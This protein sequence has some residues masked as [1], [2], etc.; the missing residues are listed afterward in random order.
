MKIAAIYDIHGNLPALEAVLNEIER[1][2]VDL[3]LVGGDVAAG[4]MPR[5]T[6]ER[7]MSL[8]N[9]AQYI[10]GNGDRYLI[11]CFDGVEMDPRTSSTSR[12][13]QGWVARQIEQ[14][15]RDFVASFA[16]QAILPVEG[17]GTVLFCH[18]SPRSD[19]EGITTTTSEMELQ[20]MLAGIRQD[21][22]VCG[23]MHVQ[24]ERSFE[25]KQVVNAGSVG[26]PYAG[27]P[28]AY[29]ALLGPS[30]LLRRTSYD[31]AKAAASF[32]SSGFPLLQDFSAQNL[33]HPNQ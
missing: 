29:W 17:L 7:L 4:P 22:V 14:K 18:G 19:V 26:L 20:E 32:H 12:L 16:V 10:R 30:I 25:G 31:I 3:I 11:D 9:K 23:H 27:E 5:A 6:I 15:H 21:V 2:R 1:E 24:F 13:V 33:L 28:G 8:G